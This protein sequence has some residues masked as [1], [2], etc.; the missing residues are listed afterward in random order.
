MGLIAVTG[1]ILG[2]LAANPKDQDFIAVFL[3]ASL[4]VVVLPEHWAIEGNRR[5]A[6][7]AGFPREGDSDQEASP[8]PV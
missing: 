8:G 4:V 3:I 1:G 5:D 7:N 2:L 6:R